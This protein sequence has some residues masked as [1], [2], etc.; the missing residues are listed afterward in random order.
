MSTKCVENLW[1][2]SNCPQLRARFS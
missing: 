1:V 2:S